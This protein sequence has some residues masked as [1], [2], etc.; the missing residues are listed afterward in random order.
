MTTFKEYLEES[1]VRVELSVMTDEASKAIKSLVKKYS[2]LDISIMGSD[3]EDVVIDGNQ[4]DID[5]FLNDLSKK[6][7]NPRN[8]DYEIIKK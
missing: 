5:K 3:G 8:A 6:V 4:K 2:I 1:S 7:K